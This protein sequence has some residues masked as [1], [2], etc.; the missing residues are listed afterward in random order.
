MDLRIPR[1]SQ[2]KERRRVRIFVYDTSITTTVSTLISRRV[3]GH[4]WI[5]SSV[6]FHAVLESTPWPGGLLA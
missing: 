1:S 2:T 6:V 5:Q 3:V 4:V